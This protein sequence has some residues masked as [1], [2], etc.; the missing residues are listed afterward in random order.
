MV[1]TYNIFYCVVTDAELRRLFRKFKRLDT[2]HSGTLSVT[3]FLAIPELEHNPLVRRVVSTF[4]RDN[5]GEVDFHEF[6]SAITVFVRAQSTQQSLNEKYEFTFR[7]YDV[8]NDGF[9]SNADLF[10]VLKNMVGNNL[11]DIQLQQLVDRT[12]IK[13]DLDKDGKLNYDE[14]IKMV[15]NSELGEKLRIEMTK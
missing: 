11:N 7:L 6:I 9:I 1:L 3:E 10:A 15:Q 13:G 8:D 4:D 12:I 14:Y 5:N 2:D